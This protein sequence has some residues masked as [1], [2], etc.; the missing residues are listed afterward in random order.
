M[1]KIFWV[2][3]YPTAKL[4]DYLVGDQHD[5]KIQHKDFATFLNDDVNHSKYRNF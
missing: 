5:E 4:L 1:I 3:A 2:L